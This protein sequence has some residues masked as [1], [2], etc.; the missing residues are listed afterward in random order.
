MR[1]RTSRELVD[2]VMDCAQP[3]KLRKRLLGT[4]ELLTHHLQL[5]LA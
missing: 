2:E 4:L 1:A 3:G 5:V